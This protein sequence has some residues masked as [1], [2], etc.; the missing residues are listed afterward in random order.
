MTKPS[1]FAGMGRGTQKYTC[2]FAV[3]TDY[4]KDSI[5][6]DQKFAFAL[7]CPPRAARHLLSWCSGRQFPTSNVGKICTNHG[8]GEDFNT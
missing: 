4:R 5:C 2:T 1:T 6:D 7:R 3:R 8:K